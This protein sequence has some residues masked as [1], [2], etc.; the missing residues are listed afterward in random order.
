MGLRIAHIADLHIRGLSRHDECVEAFDNF[1]RQCESLRVDH[2]FVAGDVF[3]SKTQNIS[4]EF[5]DLLTFTLRSWASVADVHIIVGNHD[6]NVCN[7]SRQ[8]AISPIVKAIDHPRVHLYKKSGTYE[9]SPGYVWCNFGIF[10]RSSWDRVSPVPGKINI[11]CYHGPVVGASTEAG[12][13]V[14]GDVDVS[15][16]EP[17][18]FCLLGDIHHQQFLGYRDSELKKPW[19]GYA[20]SFLQQSYGESIDHG[21]L[22]WDITS[23]DEFDV[24]FC[25]LPNSRPYVTVEWSGDEKSFVEEISKYPQMSRFRVRSQFNLTQS[26][27]HKIS[28]KTKEKNPT[29]IT[30]KI[31]QQQTIDTVNVSNVSVAREDLRNGDVLLRFVKEF[32]GD[33]Q[34]LSEEEWSIVGGLING[35]VDSM[36]GE[37]GLTAARNSK[38]SVKELEFDNTYSYGEGNV[39]D[40]SKLDGLIGVFGPNRSGKSSIFGTLMYVLFNTT[41]R[42]PIKNIHVVNERREFCRGKATFES[43][44]SRYI[45]ERQTTK[46]ENN[47]RGVTVAGT[48]LNF[49]RIDED[50]VVHDMV[51][52]LRTDT[53]KSIRKIIGTS[54]DFIMTSFSTQDDNNKFIK[55]GSTQRKLVLAKFLELGLF[56]SLHEMSKRDVADA[57]TLLKEIPDR[58]WESDIL[59][60][61]TSIEK[62]KRELSDLDSHVENKRIQLGDLQ[63]KL[64]SLGDCQRVVS[65]AQVKTQQTRV[66]EVERQ[67]V[68]TRTKLTREKVDLESKRQKL[69]QIES[70]RSQYDVSDMKKRLDA[71]RRLQTIVV[72]L[73]HRYEIDYN[74][75]NSHK[76]SAETLLT[77]P[78]GDSFRD[79]RFIKLSHESKSKI[80]EHE[81]RVSEDLEK[82]ESAQKDLVDARDDK[83][84]D[85]I[86][87]CEKIDSMYVKLSADVSRVD[88]SVH[89]L[90]MAESSYETIL[91]RERTTL[92]MLVDA[93]KNETNEEVLALRRSVDS[94][95]ADLK[96][97][98]SKRMSTSSQI[99][100][101]DRE[102]ESLI[103]K[104]AEL[105]GRRTRLK[106][107]ELVSNA[108]SKRGIP[109]RIINE[110][111]PMINAEISNIL[112]GIVDFTVELDVETD[113]NDV[114]VYINYGDSR[115]IIELC[116]GMEKT[117]SSIAI[118]VALLNVSSLPKTD[119]FVI[120]E[121][122][123]T[124]DESGIESVSRL[125]LSLKKYFRS[126]FVISHVDGVK[127]TVD[128]VLEITKS[129]KDMHVVA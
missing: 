64:A 8:D 46:V 85:A 11:A 120:D 23:R 37:V 70:V 41:D 17:Y 102:I 100:C 45:V 30:F 7:L 13:N 20:G 90:E 12:W 59:T 75:L 27:I 62:L 2:I 121:G 71:W 43:G 103:S 58:D 104:S 60:K 86:E 92:D 101:L 49:F 119:M 106:Y 40:F 129:E 36:S 38:W 47:K 57:K 76:K 91:E 116:S 110:C 67:L 112:H 51:G 56:D 54:E 125:L 77:V 111:V 4:P 52:D 29:E 63:V 78:C 122:F 126:V 96:K 124:L 109:A 105:E 108:F 14:C 61:R 74:E 95:Q 73:K 65:P 31:D 118:R 98:D 42:G 80:D 35:Y 21:F 128:R 48:K 113:S 94:V 33:S 24:S 88:V 5:I 28:S 16:F 84:I 87:K 39:I 114:N 68:E 127:D 99:A 32:Y 6:G 26:E 18:D 44:G 53:D 69:S 117:V 123:G 19:I 3:N 34:S 55:E 97:S 81:K 83:L 66:D 1:L 93:Q 9:F 79:C 10:D 107:F 50:G 72:D 25:K 89:K 82:L 15:F 115:R 22:L